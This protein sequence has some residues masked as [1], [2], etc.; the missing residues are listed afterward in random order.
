MSLDHFQHIYE[1]VFFI[2][3]A[4]HLE[5]HLTQVAS[6]LLNLNSLSKP[7]TW[8]PSLHV[9]SIVNLTYLHAHAQNNNNKKEE[10]DDN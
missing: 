2:K 1:T 5:N 8:S 6:R 10:K 4:A 3:G 9:W 7:L